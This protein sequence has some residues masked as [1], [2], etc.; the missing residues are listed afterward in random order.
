MVP[1]LEHHRNKA[2]E[3]IEILFRRT[4]TPRAAIW[5]S[6]V[7]NLRNLTLQ[8]AFQNTLWQGAIDQAETVL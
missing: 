5:E 1:T 3:Q 7:G 4:Y 8:T 6:G 2:R